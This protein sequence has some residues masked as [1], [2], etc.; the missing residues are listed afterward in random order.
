MVCW[1]DV[2]LSSGMFTAEWSVSRDEPSKPGRGVFSRS[3]VVVTRL[4]SRQNVAFNS[5]SQV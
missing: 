5:V 3:L 4:F 1:A 2:A